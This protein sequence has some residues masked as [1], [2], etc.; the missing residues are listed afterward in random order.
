MNSRDEIIERLVDG[1]INYFEEHPCDHF[2]VICPKLNQAKHKCTC[3][4]DYAECK[5]FV[6][7]L[8]N[9]A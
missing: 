6:K 1:Y 5:N 9:G 2:G 7:K 3:G 8:L 4:Y